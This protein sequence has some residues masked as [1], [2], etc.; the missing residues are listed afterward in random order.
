MEA[1]PD[2]MLPEFMKGNH[3]MRYNPGL[4]NGI[5]SDMCIESYLHAVWTRN[6]WSSGIDTADVMGILLLAAMSHGGH[7]VY[8]P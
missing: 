3:V 7:F 8:V 5:W 6:W 1:L 2:V 4:W